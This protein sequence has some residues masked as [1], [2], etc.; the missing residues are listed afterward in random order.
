MRNDWT[1]TRLETALFIT[2]VTLIASGFAWAAVDVVTRAKHKR[3]SRETKRPR[4]QGWDA[5]GPPQPRE[6]EAVSPEGARGCPGSKKF[7]HGKA[8]GS[9]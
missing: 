8:A 1:L 2:G 6:H 3:Q 7:T 5:T 4:A 9:Y